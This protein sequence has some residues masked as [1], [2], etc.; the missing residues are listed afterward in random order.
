MR[1]DKLRNILIILKK[2]FVQDGNIRTIYRFV[3]VGVGVFLV[4]F[5]LDVWNTGWVNIVGFVI[6]LIGGY[7][8]KAKLLNI[9]PF[10]DAPYPRDWWKERKRRLRERK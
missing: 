5:D 2:H 4:F 9:R 8:S 7:A 10:A 3:L 6:A 1:S